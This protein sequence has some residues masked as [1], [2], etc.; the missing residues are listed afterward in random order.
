MITKLTNKETL[1]T[2]TKH[3]VYIYWVFKKRAIILIDVTEDGGAF[4]L[5]VKYYGL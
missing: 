2:Q 4:I 1:Q 5:P 3:D